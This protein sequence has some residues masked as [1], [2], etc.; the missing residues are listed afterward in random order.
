MSLFDLIFVAA[1]SIVCQISLSIKFALTLIVHVEHCIVI[2][3]LHYRHPFTVTH[4]SY[5][6]LII[7]VMYHIKV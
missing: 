1:L 2:V 4:F 5:G 6:L 3:I 7:V